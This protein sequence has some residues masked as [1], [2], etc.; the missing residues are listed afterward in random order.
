MTTPAHWLAIQYDDEGRVLDVSP[1]GGYQRASLF[2]L[3]S[4]RAKAGW[5]VRQVPEG[6]TGLEA[7]AEELPEVEPRKVTKT[8]KPEAPTEEPPAKAA[9]KAPA[10]RSRS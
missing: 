7:F 8:I 6:T 2:V 10:S 3:S 1:F 4:G 9:K 5:T